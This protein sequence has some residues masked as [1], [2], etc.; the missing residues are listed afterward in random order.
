MNL[1]GAV[2]VLNR[3][4][5]GLQYGAALFLFSCP[6]LDP[7]DACVCVCVCLS[8]YLTMLLLYDNFVLLV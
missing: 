8:P 1:L 3:V 4:L 5:P 6:C 7:Y 2:I